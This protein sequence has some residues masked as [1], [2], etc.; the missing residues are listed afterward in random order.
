MLLVRTGFVTSTGPPVGVATTATPSQRPRFAILW[1]RGRLK[2]V[3]Q[4][5][6]PG[7]IRR[8]LFDCAAARGRHLPAASR[9]R[10]AKDSTLWRV[11]RCHE[12]SAVRLDDR[13][14]D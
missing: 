14:A 13:A 5:F 2:R 12:S 11:L 3:W 4:V 10:E 1:T 6:L 9:Q 8:A 7:G